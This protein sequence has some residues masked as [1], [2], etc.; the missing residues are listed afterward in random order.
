MWFWAI[1]DCDN[2]LPLDASIEWEMNSVNS[3][4]SQFTYSESGL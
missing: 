4:G 1:E 3:N 2:N